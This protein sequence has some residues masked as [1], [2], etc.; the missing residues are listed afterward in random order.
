VSRR[1]G[2]FALITGGIGQGR[3]AWEDVSSRIHA[4]SV[5]RV[6]RERALCSGVLPADRLSHN[7]AVV[8]TARV[9]LPTG[10]SARE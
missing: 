6:V 1:T 8:S 4:L 2:Q 7:S 3:E 5:H 9:S 10:S